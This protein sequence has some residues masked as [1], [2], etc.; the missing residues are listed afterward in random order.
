MLKMT[1]L[2]V[3]GH[4]VKVEVKVKEKVKNRFLVITPVLIKIETQNKKH[5]I[6][7]RKL[8]QM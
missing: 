3:G 2:H 5:F 1:T 4:Q 6:S 7:L 8:Y